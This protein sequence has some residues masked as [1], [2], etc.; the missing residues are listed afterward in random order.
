[1]LTPDYRV[2]PEHPYPAALEGCHSLLV[3]G[4]CHRAGLVRRLCWQ[5][6]PAGGGLAMC[7]TM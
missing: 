4:L 2:A 3:N 7:L 5:E 6:T 1:M